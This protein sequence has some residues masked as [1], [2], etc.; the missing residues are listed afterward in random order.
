MDGE[1]FQNLSI[2]LNVSS[3]FIYLKKPR[4]EFY[5]SI[6]KMWETHTV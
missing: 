1:T 3:A 6:P 2:L 4:S 5:G